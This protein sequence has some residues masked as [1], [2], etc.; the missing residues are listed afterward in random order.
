MK[1][2]RQSG[3]VLMNAVF[4][5]R[6]LFVYRGSSRLL[7]QQNIGLD[8]YFS[9]YDILPRLES[10]FFAKLIFNFN[11]NLVERWDGYILIWPSHPT[12]HP[13]YY[14]NDL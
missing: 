5:L 12:T 6:C 3:E 1:A 8:Y 4:N 13:I 9:D 14:N 7:E 10:I 2:S 11:F